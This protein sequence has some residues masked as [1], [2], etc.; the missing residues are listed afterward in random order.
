LSAGALRAIVADFFNF[1]RLM[2]DGCVVCEV[3][4]KLVNRAYNQICGKCFIGIPHPHSMLSRLY[5]PNVGYNT[6]GYMF[7]NWPGRRFLLKSIEY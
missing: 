7:Y 3:C 6:D 1:D 5:N 4:Y 2:N